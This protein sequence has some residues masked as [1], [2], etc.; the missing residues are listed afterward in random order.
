[1]LYR[2]RPLVQIG[3]EGRLVPL[4]K[5]TTWKRYRSTLRGAASCHLGLPRDEALDLVLQGLAQGA[6][7]GLQACLRTASLRAS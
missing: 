7:N 3:P 2:G 6:S 1:V 5:E 4:R